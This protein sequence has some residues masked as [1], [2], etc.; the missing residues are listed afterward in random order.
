LPERLLRVGRSQTR[1][2]KNSH[3]IRDVALAA[4]WQGKRAFLMV[5][6]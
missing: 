6:S 5:I 1:E 4:K 3:P 2:W